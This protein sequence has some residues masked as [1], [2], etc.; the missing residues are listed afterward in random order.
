MVDV[1]IT[2]DTRKA[3][4]YLKKIGRNIDGGMNK[5]LDNELTLFI[6]T[7][8]MI[9]PRRTGALARGIML[10]RTS[11]TKK[12]KSG[13]VTWEEQIPRR[14]RSFAKTSYENF[15]EWLHSGSGVSQYDWNGKHPAFFDDATDMRRK[16]VIKGVKITVNKAIKR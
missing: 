6:H 3:T 4:K 15:A 12:L 14:E 13:T 9:A 5:V 8:R 11:K 2:V 1:K 10:G 7:A 16:E